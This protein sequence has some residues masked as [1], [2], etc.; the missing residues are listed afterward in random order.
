VG[1]TSGRGW[2]AKLKL[3]SRR[4]VL[5]YWIMDGRTQQIEVY[6]REQL[7]LRLVAPLY[8]TDALTSPLLPGFVRQ[9]ATL[10]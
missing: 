9:V 1:L 4:G 6:Q 2:E 7:A 10:F 3:Y 5:E 8:S